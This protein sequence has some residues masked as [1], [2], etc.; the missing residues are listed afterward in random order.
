MGLYQTENL[1]SKRNQHDKQATNW[2]GG[3]IWKWFILNIGYSWRA[4][5][6]LTTVLITNS[7]SSPLLC[8]LSLHL[9]FSHS[10][11]EGSE[12]AASLKE[13]VASFFIPL[14]ADNRSQAPCRPWLVKKGRGRHIYD[15]KCKIL[16][17]F[18]NFESLYNL[19]RKYDS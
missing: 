13:Q 9:V 16:I 4:W 10:K 11:L 8:S 5:G 14:Q 17:N 19:E 1:H 3:D 15:G 7:N 18:L 6:L 2:M 12:T